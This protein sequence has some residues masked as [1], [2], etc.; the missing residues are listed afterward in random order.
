M[1]SLIA[2]CFILNLLMLKAQ[3]GLPYQAILLDENNTS[4][5]SVEVNV[6]V[7][8]LKGASALAEQYCEIHDVATDKNGLINL[9]IGSEDK[10]SGS[11]ATYSEIDWGADEHFLQVSFK[12]ASESDMK[13]IGVTKLQAVPYAKHAIEADRLRSKGGSSLKT[14]IYTGGM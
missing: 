10:T 12:K 11:A 13:T 5:A 9:L 3:D 14:L 7:C 1:R 6:E 8:I 4:I 2:I